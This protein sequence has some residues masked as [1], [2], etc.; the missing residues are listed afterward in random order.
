MKLSPKEVVIVTR[1]SGAIEWLRRQ[2]IEAEVIAQAT[3]DQIR[4]KNVIGALPLHLAT[5][6]FTM[7]SIAFDTPPNKRGEEL[8][9]ND[10]EKFGARL[11]T[12]LVRRVA[13]PDFTS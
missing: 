10:M 3:P 9:A 13:T 7:T 2:G 5:E 6:C 12:F 8:S 1:H 4:G 11:E